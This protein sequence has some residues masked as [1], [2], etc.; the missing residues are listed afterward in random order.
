M[1][2]T[3]ASSR[4]GGN[5]SVVT[6]V[7]TDAEIKALPSGAV[8]LIAP[9]AN[10]LIVPLTVVIGPM[11]GTDYTNIDVA[12]AFD[13]EIG[14]SP[15]TGLPFHTFPPS[16]DILT[17]GAGLGRYVTLGTE[18]SYSGSW[19]GVAEDVGN[20]LYLNVINGAAGN[21]TGGDPANTLPI[22]IAYVSYAVG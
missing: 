11:L 3:P 10:R 19:N 4:G 15:Q 9:V 21:F 6:R 1:A 22:T 16:S 13:F 14:S 20:G 17:K 8:A 7:F 5:P 12:S 2:G 18:A